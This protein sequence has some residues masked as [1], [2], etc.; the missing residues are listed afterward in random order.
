MNFKCVAAVALLSLP[1]P[2]LAQEISEEEQVSAMD[3]A[4]HDAAYSVYHEVGH[5][6]AREFDLPVLGKQE[7]AADSLAVLM[8]LNDPEDQEESNIALVDAA[9]GWWAS[10]INSEAIAAEDY[11]FDVHSLDIQRAFAMVCL[12]VGKDPEWFSDAADGYG[13]EA[14]QRERCGWDYEDTERSWT[15]LLEPYLRTEGDDG[16][17]IEVVYEDS[18]DYAIYEEELKSRQILEKAAELVSSR[19][20]LPYA[21]TFRAKLCGEANAYYSYGDSELTYC[22]EMADE[23]VARYINVFA[24]TDEEEYS[25]E[26]GSDEEYTDAEEEYVEEE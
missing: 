23:M 9:D 22:Y 4:M 20:K 7:D 10:A 26:D 12:M 21:I 18:G 14:E 15:K 2:A 8:M 25:E 17:A 16:A 24:A 1:L 6:L 19:Y 13:L 3:F 11:A 5:L